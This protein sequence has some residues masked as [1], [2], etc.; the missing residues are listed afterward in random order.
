MIWVIIGVVILVCGGGGFAV[1][2]MMGK[3]AQ[4]MAEQNKE[5]AYRVER[6]DLQVQVIETGTLEAK[7]VVEVKS[8]V[9]G[10]VARLLVDEGDMVQQGDLIAV[11]DPQ[12]TELQVQ[13]N[14]AQLKGAQSGVARTNVEIQ[15]RRVTAQTNLDRARSRLSQIELE[16]KAQPT[17]TRAAI[18]AAQ[19]TVD[20]AEKDLQ[21]LRTS[22]HPNAR[23][24]AQRELD[25]AKSSQENSRLELERRKELY[26]KGYISKRDL[27]AGQLQYDLAVTRTRS[28]QDRFNRLAQEQRLEVERAQDRLEQAQSELDRTKASAIQDDVK[29]E[30]YE[31]AL[32]DVRDA[33]VALKDVDALIAGRS[34]QQASVEQLESVLGD[35]LRQLGETE[36][37]APVSGIVTRRLVQQGEL[38][39]SLSSFSSGTP[40]VEVEDRS[41]MLV[42]LDVNEIDVARLK[43]GTETEVEV[44]ALPGELFTGYVS[45]IAPA[46]NEAAAGQL[47][48]GD[49]VRYAVEVE[50]VDTDP[51]LK[52]GMSVRTTMNVLQL[53]DVVKVRSE[54]VGGE[55]GK[56]RFVLVLDREPKGPEDK[57]ESRQV[58][59]EVGGSSGA[60]IEILS[61]VKEGEILAKPEYTGPKRRG[62]MGGPE[63]GEG[64]EEDQ[65]LEE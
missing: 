41:T 16:L 22:T 11:I 58:N 44:D 39:A 36:I 55:P 29:R 1:K 8:R 6:G 60:Y 54:Y 63:D 27:E 46:A 28:A 57:P 24:A 52:S 4:A 13:Q 26:A 35:S 50:L 14:R 43:M 38:V 33:Q 53:D 34:Q 18:A 48:G 20:A 32:R 59:V 7:K 31:R 42:Q 19:S 5:E 56:Q 21:I 40:I 30:E 49:V 12:E 37:R 62:L 25:E 17:L 2:N 64:G 65:G 9:S 3:A 15:Q 47:T 23:T 61:G 10:R 45:K 51:R